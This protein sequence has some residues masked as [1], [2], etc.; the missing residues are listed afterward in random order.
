MSETQIY[1]KKGTA[2]KMLPEGLSEDKIK[3]FIFLIISFL[4]V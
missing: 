2:S 4:E 3:T 1:I